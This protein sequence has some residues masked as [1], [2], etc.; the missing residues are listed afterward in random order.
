MTDK[1]LPER[2]GPII[3]VRRPFA[4]GERRGPPHPVGH[5]RRGLCHVELPF[6]PRSKPAYRFK[7]VI[8]PKFVG[9]L[10][11]GLEDLQPIRIVFTLQQP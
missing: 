9:L 11:H 4:H 7:K 10:S 5:D 8:R 3:V 1:F 2:G 6:Y